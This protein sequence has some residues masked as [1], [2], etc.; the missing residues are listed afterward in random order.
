MPR[1]RDREME[2]VLSTEEPT[3]Q[4]EE[5]GDER[6]SGVGR[7]W[8]A[9]TRA[10]DATTS[11]AA[12]SAGATASAL[13]RTAD[14]TTAAAGRAAGATASAAGNTLGAAASAPKAAFNMVFPECPVPAFMLPTGTGVEDYVFVFQMDEMLDNLRSGVF[15]R[16]NIVVWSARDCSYDLEHFTDELEQ[17]FV[18]QFNEA[19]EKLQRTLG[20]QVGQAATVESNAARDLKA[21][22]TG[23]ALN[24]AARWTAAAVIASIVPLVSGPQAIVLPLL[25]L[26]IGLRPRTKMVGLL[27]D[28]LSLRGDRS[29]VESDF[30]RELEE[31][32][33]SMDSKSKTLQRAVKRLEVKVHPRIRQLGIHICEAEG[34]PF[35]PGI[36]D[37]ARGETPDVGPYLNHPWYIERL[38]DRYRRFL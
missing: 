34:I 21:E 32:E 22:L 5:S 35:E 37:P 12:Q 30:V 26:A 13:G 7:V 24:S 15:V 14:A 38:P 3:D 1:K 28:Y 36:T 6:P 33:S 11:A 27:R 18:R 2:P 4:A 9:V 10:A 25:M 31:L 19:R 8:N 16:P 29:Q 20:A 17:D 23:P